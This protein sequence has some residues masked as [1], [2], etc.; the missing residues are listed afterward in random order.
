MSEAGN[1]L[2]LTDETEYAILVQLQEDLRNLERICPCPVDFFDKALAIEHSIKE[3]W[4]PK[5]KIYDTLVL[6]VDT[7][8]IC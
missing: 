4:L 1:Q 2:M 8:H 5:A 3:L 6:A 7:Y